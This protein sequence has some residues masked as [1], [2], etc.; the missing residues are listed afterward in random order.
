MQLN[1]GIAQSVL[2]IAK[3]W[4]DVKASLLAKNTYHIVQPKKK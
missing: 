2:G 1:I 4:N 3:P